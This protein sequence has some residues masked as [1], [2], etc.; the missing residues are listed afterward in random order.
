MQK[1]IFTYLILL[2]MIIQNSC[3]QEDET[4]YKYSNHLI[5]ETS[6]YLLQHAHN[7]V[8]WYPY[9]DEAFAKAQKE[10]KLILFSIGYAA[11]HWCH[12]ME[13]ES[14]ESEEIAQIMNDNFVC[15]KV[16]KE[17]RPDVDQIYMNAIQLLTGS[18]GWP[19]NCFALPDG[20]PVWGGTYFRPKDWK[21]VLLNLSSTYKKDKARFERSAQELTRGIVQTELISAKSD[22]T[23]MSD[24]ELENTVNAM[25]QRFDYQN[26]GFI[27]QPKFPMP[28]IYDFLLDYALV[29]GDKELLNHISFTLKKWAYGGI[30]DQVGGGFARYSV[31]S[32]WL[33]PHFEKMLYDN[34]QI[35]SLYAKLFR[36]T[37]EPAFKRVI[38]ETTAWTKREMTA[39][40]G[41]FY[42]SYDAD[43]E[44]E[45]GAFYVWTKEEIDDLL[46]DKSGLFCDYYGIT[47]NGN[48]EG[49]TILNVEKMQEPSREII[50]LRKKLFKQREM[51][52][53]PSLDHKTLASWNGLMISGLC[54]SYFATTNKEYLSMATKSAETMLEKYISDDGILLRL[55]KKENSVSAFMDDYAFVIKA[56]LDL[57]KASFDD[58][59]LEKSIQLTKK[60]N[61]LFF[62]ETSGMYFYTALNQNVVVRKMEITDNVIPAS[63]SVM[64]ENLYQ[65]SVLL[66][67]NKMKTQAVQILKNTKEQSL[68]NPTYSY[69]SLHL[70]L[71]LNQAKKE[72]VIV[73]EDANRKR[74]KLLQDYYPL[75]VISGTESKNEERPLFRNRYQKGKTLFYFCVNNACQL[76]VSTVSELKID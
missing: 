3:A 67:D 8:N 23:L 11:C 39:K 70:F 61:Q 38:E 26:G 12:V 24:N 9:G 57:Y 46:G 51:R 48:F 30:Y 20:Q 21:N 40:D 55:Y 74:D 14:F 19:L 52:V 22:A 62:D 35:L 76:P 71:Q 13:H 68:K 66:D 34:G 32:K 45:E 36:R 50:Q 75:I 56:F 6:P 7:P 18:G 43:S 69:K 29:N 17:E 72:L 33:V 27:G 15:V 73:G 42:A 31:D 44:G 28:G 25:K 49:K 58:K 2:I 10:D 60:A 59:W 5:N 63:N 53:K 41:M 54:E 47:K 37:K 64:A 65:L 16:D 4:K 1:I